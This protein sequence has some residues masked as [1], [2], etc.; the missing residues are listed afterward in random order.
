[1]DTADSPLSGAAGDVHRVVRIWAQVGR[2]SRGDPVTVAHVCAAAVAA[3]KVDG[4]GVTLMVSPTV[5]ETVHATD[6]VADELEEWQLTF[7]QGPCVDAFG[8]GGPV[9]AVDLGS[10]R[11]LASWPAFTPAALDSGARA[12]FALPLQVGAIRL[13]VLDLYRTRPGSLSPHELADALAFAE[14]VG[15]LLLD[16][17]AGAAPDTAELAWQR[18][19]PTAQQ[20]QVHQATG[21]I[22]VQLGISAEAAFARLR[23]YAYAHDRRLGEV[24]RDVVE[25]RLRFDPDVIGTQPPHPEPS[26]DEGETT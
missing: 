4:A 22:L 17:A 10:A 6:R 14:A 23:A 19:D 26:R 25:R 9:L 11:C 5:R 2:Q 7:G 1:V 18:N 15:M 16:T 3:V 13:G 20:A 21:M 12:V 24:A 8:D